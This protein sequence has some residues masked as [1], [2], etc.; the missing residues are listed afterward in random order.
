MFSEPGCPFAA[1]PAIASGRAASNPGLEEVE[2]APEMLPRVLVAEDNRDLR[3][4]FAR[5][6]NLL[7]LEVV[8]VDNGRDAVEFVLAACRAEILLTW[9]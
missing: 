5:Q 6:L 2:M 4:I 3:L 1:N 8:A 9:S 7:G